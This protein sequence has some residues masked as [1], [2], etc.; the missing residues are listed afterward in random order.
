M[1][2][3]QFSNQLIQKVDDQVFIRGLATKE[4]VANAQSLG[5]PSLDSDPADPD[6]TFELDTGGDDTNMAF[7]KRELFP[8]PLAKQVKISNKLL[9]MS[10]MV[11]AKV[12]ERLSYKFAIAQ[13]KGFMTG[14]G[15]EQPLG[16]FTPS[17]NG[18]STGRDVLTGSAT[19]IL[20]DSLFDAMYTLKAAYQ[21]KAVWIF[22]RDGIKIIR[23]L[24]DSQNRYLWEP[25][26][27]AGQPDLILGRPFYMSEYAPN[28]FTTGLYVGIVGDFSRYLIADA[29]SMQVQRVVE[30]YARQNQTG[31]IGRLETDG[32]PVLEE[33]FVRLKTS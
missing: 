5:V 8:H 20:A 24:K 2:S 19:S 11:D 25:A 9:R 22:H 29:L 16:V 31:F 15:A 27:T 10:P 28:T 33:A 30:L 4:T 12:I 23:K 13:E 17:A 26:I 21:A 14:S 7:G 3:E 18:I 6:W 1:A 32:M